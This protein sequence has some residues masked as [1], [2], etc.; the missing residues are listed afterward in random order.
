MTRKRQKAA[1]RGGGDPGWYARIPVV[2]TRAAC[3]RCGT[4]SGLIGQDGECLRCRLE[5][6]K[7]AR[8]QQQDADPL[9]A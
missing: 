6:R 8:E 1:K 3:S 2:D 5:R 4:R 7:A 9:P